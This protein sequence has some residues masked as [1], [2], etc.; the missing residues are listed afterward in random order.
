LI[1][2]GWSALEEGSFE[3][4]KDLKVTELVATDGAVGLYTV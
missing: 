4:Y 2:N 3:V 1:F